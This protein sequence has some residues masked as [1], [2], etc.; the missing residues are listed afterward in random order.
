MR[1]HL[2][3]MRI[4]VRRGGGR[5]RAGPHLSRVHTSWPKQK[6][7]QNVIIPEITQT[8]GGLADIY[9]SVMGVLAIRI[10]GGAL[11]SE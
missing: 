7:K 1:S 8:G 10:V 3:G 9:T 5:R 6:T 2:E 11:S 4:V